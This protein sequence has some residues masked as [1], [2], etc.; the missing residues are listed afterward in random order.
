MITLLLMSLVGTALF[1]AGLPIVLF[2]LM[3]ETCAHRAARSSR[4]NRR[5]R[6]STMPGPDPVLTAASSI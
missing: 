6:I 5:A 3:L 1:F 2:C 4:A